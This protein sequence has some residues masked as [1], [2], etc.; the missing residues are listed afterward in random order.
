MYASD[1]EFTISTDAKPLSTAIAVGYINQLH[2]TDIIP[3]QHH[4]LK[5]GQAQ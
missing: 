3:P 4:W 2:R 1:T 5:N